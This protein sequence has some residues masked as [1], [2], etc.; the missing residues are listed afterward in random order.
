MRSNFDVNEMKRY[1][2]LKLIYDFTYY[3]NNMQKLSL[4]LTKSITT[5]LNVLGL[6]K[7]LG[8]SSK[9]DYHL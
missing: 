2:Y 8:Y 9:I 3:I 5:I 7:V 1:F 4:E 6:P